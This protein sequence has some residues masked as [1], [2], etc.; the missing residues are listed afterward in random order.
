MSTETNGWKNVAG[1]RGV[2]H[3]VGLLRQRAGFV[4]RGTGGFTRLQLRRNGARPQI[5]AVVCGRND[6][7]MS[8]F[9]ARLHATIAW[10][11]KYLVDEVIFIEWNPPP[12][13]EL[14]SYDLAKKFP[15]LRAY[16]VPAEV[17]TRICENRN[18][19]L[20]EY[21][22][23]NVGVRR[24]QSP[25]VM[26][27]N[28]D[29]AMG[30]DVVNTILNANLERDVI[31]TAERVDISWREDEQTRIDLLS[32]LRYGRFIPYHE[33]GTGEF[34]LAHRDLWHQIR[35]YD[36]KLV[37]HRI[38]C[39]VR[40]TAQMR[41]HGAQIKRAGT[42]LH[43]RHPTSC[44]EGVRPF[45]GEMATVEGVPYEND[46]N[47]GLGSAREVQLAERVWRLE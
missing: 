27:T 42:V 25:W 32:S 9:A 15:H 6:D 44:A 16:V 22:A 35:G 21:H 5:A 20:L 38:G 29:A 45:H 37:K 14:L 30:F 3:R 26:A 13:R 19:A 36:E 28:A 7:Y 43:L 10:N 46:E 12:D 23:K 39:D 8:D 24:A 1:V 47:W 4:M 18:V 17:H 34:V 40:G 41:A 2:I 11:S 31:W 33:L